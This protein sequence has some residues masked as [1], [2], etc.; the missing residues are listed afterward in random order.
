[1]CAQVS[2]T[3]D[4]LDKLKGEHKISAAAGKKLRIWLLKV[5]KA[6]KF[7][8]TEDA[9]ESWLGVPDDTDVESSQV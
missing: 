8:I 3:K 5:S 9:L 4:D 2:T 1:M 6:L 7:D